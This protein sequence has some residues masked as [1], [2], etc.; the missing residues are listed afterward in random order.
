MPAEA[1]IDDFS[2]DDTDIP[3]SEVILDSVGLDI[4]AHKTV[5]GSY[6]FFVGQVKKTPEGELIPA[7]DDEDVWAYNNSGEKWALF[8]EVPAE[9]QIDD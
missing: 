8:N 6:S 7:A 2:V 5:N 1:E 3:L 9:L 4:S